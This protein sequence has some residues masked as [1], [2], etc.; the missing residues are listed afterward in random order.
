MGYC[1]DRCA[2]Q[3]DGCM[4]EGVRQ[5][6]LIFLKE[7]GSEGLYVLISEL[8]FVFIQWGHFEVAKYHGKERKQVLRDF[9]LG[10]LDVGTCLQTRLDFHKIPDVVVRPIN[11][12]ILIV[13]AAMSLR[14]NRLR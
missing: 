10:R 7:R 9:T 12:M 5:G 4:D 2:E 13:H 14:I 1:I 11:C 8:L 3:C 6:T